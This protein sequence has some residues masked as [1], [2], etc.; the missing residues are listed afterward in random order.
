MTVTISDSVMM[1]KNPI[2]VGS[3]LKPNAGGE[4]ADVWYTWINFC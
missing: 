4:L 1:R 3:D 2:V